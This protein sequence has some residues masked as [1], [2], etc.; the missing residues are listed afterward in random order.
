[1]NHMHLKEYHR[2]VA[3]QHRAECVEEKRASNVKKKNNPALGQ[4][5]SMIE[6]YQVP[7]EMDKNF[8]LRDCLFGEDWT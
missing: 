2:V 6:L 7:L 5:A 3:C 8:Q 4:T 1:M